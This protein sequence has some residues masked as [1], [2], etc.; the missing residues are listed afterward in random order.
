V[1][2]VRATDFGGGELPELKLNFDEANKK[3]DIE[4]LP[5]KIVT[6]ELERGK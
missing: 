1:K 4:F 6:L 5:Y 3:A 2:S